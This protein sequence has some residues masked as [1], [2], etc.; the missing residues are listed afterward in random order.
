[1]EQGYNSVVRQQ[2]EDK[3]Y[4]LFG[5]ITVNGQSRLAIYQI[6]AL[7]LTPQRFAVEDFADRFDTELS[8]PIFEEDGPTA[9]A[10]IQKPTDFRF[11]DSIRLVGYTLHGQ[12]NVAG[13]GVNL[14]LYWQ[15]EAPVQEAYSVSTQV[16]DQQRW[17]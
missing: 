17:L 13:G 3:G 14:T 11:G 10:Q 12:D 6:S 2:I 4:Q 9:A 16:I 15:A 5:D 1:M 7:P 8:G